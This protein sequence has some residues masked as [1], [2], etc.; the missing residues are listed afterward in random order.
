MPGEGEFLVQAHY[1]SVDSYMRGRMNDAA[2]MP[3]R[4]VSVT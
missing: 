2:S 3:S 1:L 4:L